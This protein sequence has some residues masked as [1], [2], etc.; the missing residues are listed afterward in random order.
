MHHWELC[1]IVMQHLFWQL[2]IFCL[3]KFC[4]FHTR[5]VVADGCALEGAPSMLHK[6]HIVT[7]VTRI[8]KKMGLLKARHALLILKTNIIRLW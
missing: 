5:V 7:S 6:V 1:L 3:S 2:K 8:V 4:K